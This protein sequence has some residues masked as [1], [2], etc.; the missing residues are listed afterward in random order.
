M[1]EQVENVSFHPIIFRMF[2]NTLRETFHDAGDSILFQMS[3]NFSASAMRIVGQQQDVGVEADPE[4]IIKVFSQRMQDSGWGTFSMVKTDFEL[5]DFEIQ[6]ESS[7]FPEIG[8]EEE[9][10][11]NYFYRGVLCGFVEFLTRRPM[12]IKQ[13]ET[14]N[15]DGS[16]VF[17]IS[18]NSL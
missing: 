8:N 3:K 16:V 5:F 15:A 13:C 7:P 6:L 4:M 1:S 9:E 14:L 11:M 18:Q 17:Y 12:R 2:L 10:I